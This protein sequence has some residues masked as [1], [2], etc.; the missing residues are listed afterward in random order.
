MDETQLQL[1][2]ISDPQDRRLYAPNRKIRSL[3]DAGTAETAERMLTLAKNHFNCVGI[4]APQV[5]INSQIIVAKSVRW[6]KWFV[7]YNPRIVEHSEEKVWGRE[8]CLSHPGIS[9]DVARYKWIKINAY[10]LEEDRE[11]TVTLADD[12]PSEEHPFYP[13]LCRVMQ[14]ELQHIHGTELSHENRLITDLMLEGR[15]REL[16]IDAPGQERLTTAFVHNLEH[17]YQDV[18]SDG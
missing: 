17:G 18:E 1:T 13:S 2:I 8:G 10:D 3:R 16:F 11:I 9:L 12:A 4:A 14:H 7:L 6:Q 5:G 15:G